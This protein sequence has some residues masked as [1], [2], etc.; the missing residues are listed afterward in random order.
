MRDTGCQIIDCDR[1]IYCF[2]FFFVSVNCSF[3][4]LMT[5]KYDLCFS[6]RQPY[7]TGLY[8]PQ[9]V[10]LPAHGVGL[11]HYEVTIA[12]ALRDF[13]GYATGIVGKW[14]LGESSVVMHFS[15]IVHI[16]VCN[17]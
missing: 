11:P 6:G 5:I 9:L 17:M 10:L 16:L 7:R 15:L 2:C 1:F 14:H 13:A 4:L 8:G 3:T 12:E